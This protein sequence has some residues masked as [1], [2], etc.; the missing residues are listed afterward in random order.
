MVRKFN[1]G[2][3]R[4][5]AAAPHPD[6]T[7]VVAAGICPSS[8]RRHLGPEGSHPV[9]EDFGRSAA[10]TYDQETSLGV[11]TPVKCSSGGGQ[12]PL[13]PLRRC[14]R[15]CEHTSTD[16]S[17]VSQASAYT[18]DI[19][20]LLMAR[21]LP[22]ACGS[23]FRGIV[24]HHS[25][26]RRPR[27]RSPWSRRSQATVPS[28]SGAGHFGAAG[29]DQAAQHQ[30][31]GTAAPVSGPLPARRVSASAAARTSGLSAPA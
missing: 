2:R 29:L 3:R 5:R 22:A 25:A 9:L 23:G 8:S 30:D 20:D 11:T 16:R 7:R 27:G 19:G 17:T 21:R 10:Q 24:A 6:G 15:R 26:R 14:V 28:G 18:R 13:R 31:G 4:W 1:T 12:I